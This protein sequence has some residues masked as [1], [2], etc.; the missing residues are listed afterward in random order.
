MIV[1]AHL[2]VWDRTVSEYAWIPPGPLARSFG[3]DDVRVALAAAGV[4]AVVLVQAE[5]SEADTHAMLAAAGDPLVA[6][7]VG[8]VRLDDPTTAAAQLGAYGRRLCGVR[9]LVHDDPRDGLLDLPA[10][11]ASLRLV[12]EAGLAF[13]VPDAW[14]RHLGAVAALAD[15]L[16]TLPVVVDHLGKPP[17]GT[18]A[19]DAW[20]RALR[21]VA[22][23]PR[24]VA[25]V[26]GL[27][28]PGQPFTA[29]ALRPVWDVALDAFGPARLMYGGDWPMTAPEGG[30]GPHWAVV[31]ELI[32]E[33]SP[34]EQADVLAGTATRT[35]ALR[36]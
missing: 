8:W 28:R 11:R 17:R 26:S 16:E 23:R 9:H 3:L 18:D 6:G 35:Y 13:D 33:L 20:E 10:V 34:A 24:A 21:A 4:E 29:Q 2:H 25:K 36:R 32:D 31:R 19:M 5:D 12:A 27:A 30:Y 14:P 22:A 15:A 7:V 1:D